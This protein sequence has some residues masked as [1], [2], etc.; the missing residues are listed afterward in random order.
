MYLIQIRAEQ[1]LVNQG[2][3]GRGGSAP[4]VHGRNGRVPRYNPVL[5]RVHAAHTSKL[6]RPSGS[7]VN[8][9]TRRGSSVSSSFAAASG[10]AQS[11]SIGRARRDY[12]FARIAVAGW[13]GDHARRWKHGCASAR[14]LNW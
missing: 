3:T 12:T 2:W 13:F 4:V 9:G 11:D 7:C 1:C 6:T 5:L 8:V 14:N 10:V